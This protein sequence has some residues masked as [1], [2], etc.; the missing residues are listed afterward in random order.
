MVETIERVKCPMR[1][2]LLVQIPMGEV[3]VDQMCSNVNLVINKENLTLDLIVLES[4]DIPVVLDNGWLCA[5]K[6]VIHGTECTMLLI[7]L[8]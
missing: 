2:P 8:S 5:H 7:T 1:K 3:Q 4:L 6:G